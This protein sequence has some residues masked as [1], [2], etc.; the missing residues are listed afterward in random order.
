MFGARQSGKT[1]LL[2]GLLDRPALKVNLADPAERARLLSDPDTLRREC[3]ALPRDA[4]AQRVFIDEAQRVPHVFDTVQVL[5][6]ADKIRWS[7]VLCGSSARKLRKAG[8]NLLP[9]RALLHRLYPLVMAERPPPSASAFSSYV[10]PMDPGEPKSVFPEAD[11]EERLAY[12]EFPGIA[13]LDEADRGPIL[14]S[15]A[16]AHLE[17]EIRKE[18]LVED[19]GA[20][21]NFLRLAASE[22]GRMLNYAAISQQIGIALPTVK[23]HYRLLDDMFLGFTLPAFARSPRKNLLSTPRFFFVDAGLCHAA[24]GLNPSRDIVQVDPGRFFE[25]WVIAE[26]WKRS[27]YLHDAEL[28]YLCTKDGAEIDVI[29]EQAE[30]LTPVEVKWTA[31]PSRKDARHLMRFVQEQPKASQGYIVCRCPRPQ[32]ITECVTAIPWQCL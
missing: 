4:T 1:T 26:L 19:W 22:S 28:S 31:R 11:L 23:S 24:R 8:A 5:Y 16:I 7:F 10:L 9:G 20:F 29:V 15:Y 13:L 18:G 25:Q 3:E 32:R 6:D 14:K 30:R 21:V 12:G 17:E 27:R 2:E